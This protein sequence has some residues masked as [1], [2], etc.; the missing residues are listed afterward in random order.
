[1]T[2]MGRIAVPGL[3]LA[4]SLALT[5]PRVSA[6]GPTIEPGTPETPGGGRSR[7]GPSPGEV[8]GP[9]DSS[10]GQQEGVIGGRPGASTPR[11][12]PS[13]TRPGASFLPEGRGVALPEAL[14]IT[15]VPVYGPLSVPAGA[16]DEGP[17]NGLTLDAA[18]ERLR[19]V[20]LNLRAQALEIP[21]AEADILTASLR[22]NPVFYA[23]S[24]LIPYGGFPKDRPGGQTQ[25]DVNI[26]YPLDITRKRRARMAVACQA[27][28]VVEAQFQDAVRLQIDNLYTAYVDVL[29][30]RETARFAQAS[31]TGL[32]KLLQLTETQRRR[33]FSSPAEVNRV[34]IQR[35]AAEIGI[36]E[37]EATLR[38]AKRTLAALLRIPP[39][40][41]DAV[42]LRATI[43]DVSP[44]PPPEE[45]LIGLALGNRPDIAAFRLG[46]G[47]AQAEVKLSHANRLSDIYVLYQPFTLQDNPSSLKDATSWALG[48]TVP[49]PIYNRNQGNIRR[50]QVNVHQTKTELLALEE[51]V[52]SD[53]VKAREQYA[54]SRASVEGIERD[55]LPASRQ[56]L[57]TAQELYE[58][59]QENLAFY[60][61]AQRDYNE[62]VRQ[63]RDT[64]VRHRRNM[65]NLNTVV[66]QR[67]L[68]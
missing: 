56:V 14:P 26:S 46:V 54:V 35:D 55:L 43:R 66:G 19:L 27:K 9:W 5:A 12:P 20:N 7:L 1:M 31:R 32:E 11:V 13:V 60:L 42:E 37:A 6:Q 2:R 38:Q 51:Q 29:A 18:I 52:A 36:R 62:I 59:G 47:R 48:V 65:L 16:E 24:Q 64:L 58:S 17:P 39:A 44:P 28:R 10:P 4:V 34:R 50:A 61:N 49:L 45:E 30:A 22:A 63:Y 41:G 25:Y 23:D 3:L 67:V 15:E 68:P 8:G 40:Q 57:S 53:V 33:Q 21:Q